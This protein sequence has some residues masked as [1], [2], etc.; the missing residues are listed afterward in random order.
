[1]D[2][3]DAWGFRSIAFTFKTSV[4][5]PSKSAEPASYLSFV[6]EALI[7]DSITHFPSTCWNK[8]FFF[9]CFNTDMIIICF[10]LMEHNCISSLMLHKWQF[11]CSCRIQCLVYKLKSS[12]FYRMYP[13]SLCQMSC[14]SLAQTFLF[15]D[16]VELLLNGSN[17]L[18]RYCSLGVNLGKKLSTPDVYKSQCNLLI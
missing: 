1:M 18:L 5:C 15:Y 12:S 2:F 11:Y 16:K 10:V 13:C 7:L 4:R 6:D 14:S 17:L 8:N 3:E 9:N